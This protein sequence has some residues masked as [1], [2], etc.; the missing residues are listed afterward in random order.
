MIAPTPTKAARSISWTVY[1]LIVAV[2]GVAA[3]LIWQLQ[4]LE[5]AKWCGA[6]I[7]TAKLTD[8]SLDAAKACF[9]LMAIMLEIYKRNTLALIAVLGLSIVI[10]VVSTL[11]MRVA[12]N[13]P[14]GLGAVIGD[15]GIDV[16]GR[17]PTTVTTTTTTAP[18]TPPV[19]VPKPPVAATTPPVEPQW[20]R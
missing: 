12:V 19:V 11:R 17:L 15:D 2:P 18:A 20:R 14:G 3:I 16:S 8:S 10:L 13:A 4:K 6:A 1:A 7:G 9:S 5:P